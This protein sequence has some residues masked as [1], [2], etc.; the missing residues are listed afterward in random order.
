MLV[1]F[2]VCPHT[3]PVWWVFIVC[4]ARGVLIGA[5]SAVSGDPRIGGADGLREMLLRFSLLLGCCF[6]AAL[7]HC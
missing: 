5:L 7:A 3:T 4:V 1:I 2:I 6:R